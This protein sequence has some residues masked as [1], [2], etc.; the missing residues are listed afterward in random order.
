[1]PPAKK[2]A[3]PAPVKEEKVVAKVVV[4][5]E[6]TAEAPSDIAVIFADYNAKLTA[7]R[8]LNAN[9]QAEFKMIQKRL[10]RELKANRKAAEKRQQRN[11]ARAPSGFVKPTLISD[12][13][14]DFL[15]K[16]K[17]TMIARTE[18]TREINGYIR[19]NKLQDPANG[20]KINPD[21]KLKKLLALKAT[22][23]LTYFNLQRYMSSHFQKSAPATA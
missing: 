11:A 9:L 18:V 19:A 5:E 1:M 23:E 15:S 17:G 22:D 20:R 4:T 7:A 13:L 6:K 12:A 16:P 2:S 3:T 14:A 21:A 8:Q 10:E